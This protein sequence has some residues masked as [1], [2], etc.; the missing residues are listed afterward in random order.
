MNVD[1]VS[2]GKTL[3][4]FSITWIEKN[5]MLKSKL[6]FKKNT[7]MLTSK[8]SLKVHN[9]HKNEKLEKIM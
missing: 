4:F 8:I 3:I 1:F 9:G 6:K 7:C 5:D 2:H